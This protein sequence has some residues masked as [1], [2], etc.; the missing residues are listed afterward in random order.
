MVSSCKKKRHLRENSW[1]ILNINHVVRLID[2]DKNHNQQYSDL[3]MILELFYHKVLRAYASFLSAGALQP[4][5]V[6]VIRTML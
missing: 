6:C 2:Y 5:E 1:V 4:D 3:I